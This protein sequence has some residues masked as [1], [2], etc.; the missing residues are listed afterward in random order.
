MGISLEQYRVSVG[1]FNSNG[2]RQFN[3]VMGMPDHIAYRLFCSL[4]VEVLREIS[5]C[6]TVGL[7]ANLSFFFI[8]QILLIVCSDVETNP[9][10]NNQLKVCHANVNSLVSKIDL[11]Q[12]KVINADIICLTESKL[13]PSIENADILLT[14]FYEP[15]RLDRNRHGGGIAIY[16][17]F[18]FTFEHIIIPNGLMLCESV[19]LKLK[20][21]NKS[22][23]L[24]CVYRRPDLPVEWWVQLGDVFDYLFDR[25]DGSD[26][27]IVGDFNEDLLRRD[28]HHLKDLISRFNCTQLV[29]KPT[30]IT[31]TSSSLLDPLIVN[32]VNLISEWDLLD[33]ILSDHC[34]VIATL[35]WK[36]KSDQSYQK[37][38]WQYDRANY[39]GIRA[40]LQAVDWENI[41]E[42]E[43]NLNNIGVNLVNT[44]NEAT[45]LY[46]PNNIITIRPKDKPWMKTE[47]RTLMRTRLRAYRKARASNV[48]TDWM[49]YNEL[50]NRVI[51]K[52]RQAKL[53]FINKKAEKIKTTP[54]N[55]REWWKMVNEISMFRTAKK[56]IPAIKSNTDPSIFITDPKHKAE[57]FNSYFASIS[58]VAEKDLE[59][60]FTNRRTQYNLSE[61]ITTDEEIYNIMKNLKTNKSTGPDE[62][63]N[64][65]LK[66]CAS[67]LKTPLRMAF[68]KFL[69]NGHFPDIWKVANLT[70]IPKGGV[71]NETKDYRPISVTSNI[72]KIL[73]R[74]VYDHMIEFLLS[75]NLIFKYQAGFLANN[76]TETQLIELYH[77]ICSEIDKR[78]GIQ[79]VFCDYSKAF[80][81]VWHKGLLKK[82]KSHGIDG[83]LLHWFESYLVNRKQCVV[84][85]SKKSITL[86]TKAGVPQGSV[87]G[88][89][90][91]L[92][93]INDIQDV[94]QTNLRQF[95]D[96]A[97]AFKG[98][99]IFEEILESLVPDLKSMLHWSAK[100]LMNFNPTKT[101]GLNICLID[102]VRQPL[103]L[104]GNEIVDVVSHKHLGVIFNNKGTW[105]DHINYI[106]AKALKKI[107]I[108]RSLKY[109]F[110]RQTLETM[111]FS[112]VRSG[113]EYAS[114]VWDSCTQNETNQLESIQ[115]DAARIVTGLPRYCSIDRLFVEVGWLSLQK[116]REIKKLILM[117]KIFNNLAPVYLTELLPPTVGH[118]QHHFLR[119]NF[120]IHNFRP[121]TA[122]FANSY[123]PSTIN[124][125]NELDQDIRSS[126]SIGQFVYRLKQKYAINKPPAWYL[127]GNRKFNI[128]LCRLRNKCSIL[129]SDLFRCNLVDSEACV[130]GYQTE[131]V[132]HY[133]FQC[134]IYVM[135][136][137][138]LMRSMSNI[139]L[140]VNI[141]NLNLLLCGSS[142]MS[143]DKNIQIVDIVHVYMS[144]TK[145][146]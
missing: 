82:I 109:T 66:E 79:F 51:T 72:G 108:L 135:Q 12:S 107:G 9:G 124:L 114:S 64:R 144:N 14:E 137:E 32:N 85:E 111:Y 125:W 102:Q 80:D 75:N 13:G 40:Y 29:D 19:W 5:S 90:L 77:Q 119:N 46:V 103:I 118:F 49:K 116:R 21:F 60:P 2:V 105:S 62:V 25:F 16:V 133:F 120:N 33:P 65:I 61:I 52:I 45:Q 74:V 130:C 44:I 6:L 63:N 89:L 37:C 88:P 86:E 98:Y 26:F 27:V 96:D 145:R 104:D 115:I 10:P 1:T 3:P 76:S 127:H 136:R 70:P 68:N 131:S 129:K 99:Q 146:F 128:L 71:S 54:H 126:G 31:S 38:V 30:R 34:A 141:I 11:L 22:F 139:G 110:D 8:L 57:E 35:N 113:I 143:Y 92:L 112:F 121:R 47:I 123:F 91:F 122:I 55:N 134:P 17:K 23:I 101:E 100:W 73:E 142:N 15:I 7:L 43:Q 59:V 106:S 138:Q 140:S 69:S 84:I 28:L 58:N 117:Y 78:H 87:L 53:D 67:I 39:E 4:L 81:K 83:N 20:F 48:P 50:R 18:N 36:V 24:G 97:S 93:Y 132:Y 94:I 42:N 41:I 56:A 95:A